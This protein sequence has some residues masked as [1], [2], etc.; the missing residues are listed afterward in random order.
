MWQKI[1]LI[2]IG[3]GTLVLTGWAAWV[4]FSDAE[5]PLLIK[6]TVGAVGAG[7][8]ILIGVVVKDRMTK[9]KTEDFKG[10]EQ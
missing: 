1:A 9:A 2:L 6:I 5:V 8:L 7:I 4:F 3:L 10:V